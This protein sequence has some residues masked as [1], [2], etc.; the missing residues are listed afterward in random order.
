METLVPCPAS[1]VEVGGKRSERHPNEVKD[2]L[3]SESGMGDADAFPV[4]SDDRSETRLVIYYYSK[5]QCSRPSFRFR[6]QR[7]RY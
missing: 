3:A 2:C 5:P 4:W 7:E 6:A 1:V